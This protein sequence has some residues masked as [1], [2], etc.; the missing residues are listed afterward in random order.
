MIQTNTSYNLH[1]HHVILFPG[2]QAIFWEISE[3]AQKSLIT[4]INETITT[5]RKNLPYHVPFR[6]LGLYQSRVALVNSTKGLI[7]LG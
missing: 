7:G 5:I 3:E 4:R 6:N 1:R 2:C